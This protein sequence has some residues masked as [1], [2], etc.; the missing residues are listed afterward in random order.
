MD[1]LKDIDN[2]K[3]IIGHIFIFFVKK[4]YSKKNKIDNYIFR[5]NKFWY[6]SYLL[7]TLYMCPKKKRYTIYEHVLKHIDKG[8]QKKI[9][10]ML[11]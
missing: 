9:L 3:L 2:N 5:P 8:L 6:M 10:I 4:N 11:N 1:I 7:D